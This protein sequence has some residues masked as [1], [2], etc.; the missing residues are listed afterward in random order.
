VDLKVV[1]VAIRSWLGE[2]L[3]LVDWRQCHVGSDFYCGRLA[4]CQQREVELHLKLQ[5]FT[6]IQWAARI[7]KCDERPLRE[8]V[9]TYTKHK[10][11]QL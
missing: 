11:L 5:A 8:R 10:S 1:V 6:R 7:Q 9:S 3:M 4:G 2:A